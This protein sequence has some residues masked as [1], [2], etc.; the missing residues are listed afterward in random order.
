MTKERKYFGLALLCFCFIF[1][2]I[3]SISVPSFICSS[4]KPTITINNYNE[5]KCSQTQQC[6]LLCNSVH[7]DSTMFCD[8]CCLEKLYCDPEWEI[9]IIK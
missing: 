2:L 9:R 5:V 3:F 8:Y 7:C 4:V 1:L 6:E